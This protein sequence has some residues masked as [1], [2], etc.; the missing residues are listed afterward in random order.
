IGNYDQTNQ[1]SSVIDCS[2]TSCENNWCFKNNPLPSRSGKDCQELQTTWSTTI[3]GQEDPF[4]DWKNGDFRINNNAQGPL[5]NFTTVFI[6]NPI[7]QNQSSQEKP[8]IKFNGITTDF[9]TLNLNNIKPIIELSQHGKISF[10]QTDLSRFE[11]DRN[12][13][14]LLLNNSISINSGKII[15]NSSE[16]PEL[17]VSATLE[18]YNIVL[19]SPKIL[20]NGMECLETCQNLSYD[21]V[22][23]K[24]SVQVSHFSTFEVVEGYSALSGGG[25]SGGGSYFPPTKKTNITINQTQETKTPLEDI[26][27]FIDNL[28]NQEKFILAI[29]II[30]LI[31]I[32]SNFKRKR[33]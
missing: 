31:T 23:K 28:S 1:Y 6:T 3:I 27:D 26:N 4:V 32:A 9:L 21:P 11:S 30:F 10:S 22:N 20:L 12:T 15:F 16:I 19:T 13:L 2:A 24:L 25:G 29:I 17:N 7:P 18:F 14:L 33:K 8:N 5:P